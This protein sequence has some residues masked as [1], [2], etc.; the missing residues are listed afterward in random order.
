MVEAAADSKRALAHGGVIK[1]RPKPAAHEAPH[2]AVH[3]LRAE[4]GSLGGGAGGGVRGEPHA[5]GVEGSEAGAL[6]D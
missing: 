5:G 3:A 2:T 6:A 4:P 1:P